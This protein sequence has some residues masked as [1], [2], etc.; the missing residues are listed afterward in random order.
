[1]L[2]AVEAPCASAEMQAPPAQ[3]LEVKRKVSRLALPRC[4]RTGL[5]EMTCVEMWYAQDLTQI[6]RSPR[7]TR[8][9]KLSLPPL[10]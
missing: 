10:S 5:L 8:N 3:V 7:E 4:A 1:M 6:N 2:S 9:L